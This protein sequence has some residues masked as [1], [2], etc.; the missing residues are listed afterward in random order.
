MP[1]RKGAPEVN[2]GSMADIAFLLLIFF[3]VTTKFPTDAG[4]PRMLPPMIEDPD[5]KPPPVR[6]KN[7][8]EVSINGAGMLLVEDNTMEF[9]EIKDAA[10]AFLD[11]N[12]DG[13]CKHCQGARLEDSSDNPGKAIV[14]L[15]NARQTEYGVYLTVQNELMAAYNFLRNSENPN[16]YMAWITLLWRK[17]IM[18]KQLRK[19]ER[20]N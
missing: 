17:S 16:V 15:K 3:L 19:L 7:L 2:A 4:V 14:S 12:G 13:S 18:T 8:F 11:N 9:S 1:R 5:V 10:I 20:M 6:K